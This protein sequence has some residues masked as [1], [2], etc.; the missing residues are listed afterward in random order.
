MFERFVVA[1]LL[2]PEEISETSTGLG[3]GILELIARSSF[4][5]Q[6][7]LALLLVFSIASW[8]IIIFKLREFRRVEN[9]T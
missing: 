3:G 9:D 4:I 8:A 1:L 2:Q 5:S 6:G 7:V